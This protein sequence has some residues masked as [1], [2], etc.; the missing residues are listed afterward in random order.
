VNRLCAAN[1]EHRKIRDRLKSG[2]DVSLVTRHGRSTPLVWLTVDKAT[3]KNHRNA[4]EYRV[5]VQLA[6][7]LPAKPGDLKPSFTN[8]W[9]TVSAQIG[10]PISVS[11]AASFSMLF[12]TQ[13]KG[14]IGSP[15]V[16]G[17]TRRLPGLNWPS[18]S[19]ERSDSDLLVTVGDVA[20]CFTVEILGRLVLD[21]LAT[22][23]PGTMNAG[24]RPIKVTWITITDIG[25]QALIG[26]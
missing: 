13:I 9:R 19:S 8:S 5:L 23:M 15:S 2:E 3:L 22:A 4:Y 14:R 16:T 24:G 1:R 20:V 12:D 7:A 17:S 21:G 18:F 26:K 6:E 10:C 11:A 25:R